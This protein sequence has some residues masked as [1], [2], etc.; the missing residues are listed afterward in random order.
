MLELVLGRS[1]TGK[2]TLLCSR[3]AEAARSG[4]KVLMLVPEQFSFETEKKM[5]KALRGKS[6]LNLSVLSFSRLCENIF[7]TYGG[8]AGKRLDD[9]SRLVLMK[10]AIQEMSDTLELYS[11]QSRRTDFL[12]TMLQT[13]EELKSSGTYPQ[14]LRETIAGM[15]EGQ[16]LHKLKD[17]TAIYE[18]YQ[19][20]VER[21][22]QDPLDDITRAAK[23]ACGSG[24]FAQYDIFIDGF[25]FFSPPERRLIELMLEQSEHVTLAL[26]SDG[27]NEGD[28]LDIFHDQKAA[29]R[30][31][32]RRCS[33]AEVKCKKPLTLEENLRAKKP[34]LRAVEEFMALG[35]RGENIDSDG[36]TILR[37]EDKYDEIRY[38]A[39]EITRLVRDEGYR[40][41]DIAVVC[42]NLSDYETALET[43][44]AA[45]S[46]PLFF[47][48]KEQVRSRPIISV[49]TAALDAVRGNWKTEAILRI[50]RSPAS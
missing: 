39:A 34:S 9:M 25:S 37:G 20:I 18:A 44:F 42:R 47:D 24:F 40:Y 7:R 50:A 2:T 48:K 46:I 23:L 6:S 8:L 5:L 33:I 21:N 3:G 27:L 16:L 17:I 1:G 49:M 43:I 28:D 15:E 19:G 22:Y 31:F 10:L 35:T 14:Q 29:A 4:K 12:T 11:R 13:V 36:V 38:A 45:Y 30:W 32:I 26:C 41:R